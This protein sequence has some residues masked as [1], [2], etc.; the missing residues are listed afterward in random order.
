MATLKVSPEDQLQRLNKI[1]AEVKNIQKMDEDVLTQRPAPGKWSL[2]EIVGHLNAIYD[3]YRDRIS[4]TLEQLPEGEWEQNPFPVRWFPGLS[5]NMMRP[6]GKERKWKMK[7]LKKFEPGEAAEPA[8]KG[9]IQST[10]TTFFDH[11]QHL[12]Q[13]ILN[14]R[15]KKV[16]NA[17]LVSSIGPIVKFY[18]PEAFEFLLAHEERH[19]VQMEEVLEQVR[20]AVGS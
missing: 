13:A 5:I 17:K 6:K 19:M 3:I 11:H 15:Q 1:V 20:L 9:G 16:R 2:T 7:T 14:S 8:D 12:R 4:S 10:F 18:L